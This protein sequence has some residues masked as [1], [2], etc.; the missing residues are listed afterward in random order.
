MGLRS[1]RAWCRYHRPGWYCAQRDWHLRGP[2][3]CASLVTERPNHDASPETCVHKRGFCKP[4]R[5]PSDS[6]T[7]SLGNPF[8]ARRDAVK[9]HAAIQI[10]S[11]ASKRRCDWPAVAPLCAYWP[12]P[13]SRTSRLMPTA[14][15]WYCYHRRGWYWA[16]NDWHP[17]VPFACASFLAERPV[18]VTS[19]E[20]CV[21]KRNSCKPPRPP[22]NASTHSRKPSPR[23][24]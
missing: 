1:A 11:Q 8:P 21:H 20:T 6:S 19:P 17:R 2:F 14:R 13:Q 16:R 24:S 4:P 12:P 9:T 15:A 5:P 7:R 10:A 3:A 22:S 18:H 23:A